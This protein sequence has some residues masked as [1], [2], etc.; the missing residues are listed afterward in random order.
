MKFMVR[1]QSGLQ[2]LIRVAPKPVRFAD[3]L[4]E[5]S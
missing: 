2:A 4:K 1:E 5:P 3:T